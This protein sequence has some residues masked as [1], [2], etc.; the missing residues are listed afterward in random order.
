M[1][2]VLVLGAD[3]Q[4]GRCLR[5][6]EPTGHEI[7]YAGR[8]ECDL[9]RRADLEALLGRL[10]PDHVINCAAYTRVD[11]AERD[12]EA[13]RRLNVEAPGW[14]AE[15]LAARQGPATARLIHLS[16]DYVFSGASARPWRP[17]DPPNPGC[18]YGE[19]KLAG[20]RLVLA[21]LPERAMVIRTAWLYSAFGA[22]FVKAM[23]RLMA[24]KERLQVVDDQRGSPTWGLSLAR[25]LWRLVDAFSPG[26]HHWTDAGEAS[27][28]EFA[29]A[30]Q[31][32]A[33][34]LGLL[35]RAIPIEPIPTRDYPTP[36]TRPAYSVL[37]CASLAALAKT[38]QIPWRVSLA[39][40]LRGLCET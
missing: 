18:V 24:A 8:Q 10:A 33:R 28:H 7:L 31:Q 27:W 21:C 36:A 22:N 17:D 4:L 3:G 32:E 5:L 14:I 26:V 2:R 6:C 37:D 9:G 38:P 39:A 29:T 40:M 16:T 13:A 11:R 35:R 19:T 1:S 34:R 20:E 30:I 15:A 25:V 12:R 23:L